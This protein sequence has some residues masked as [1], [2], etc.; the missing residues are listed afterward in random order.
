MDLTTVARVAQRVNPAGPLPVSHD[1]VAIYQNLIV[2][3]SEGVRRYLDRET[4]VATR[5][6]YLDVNEW[7]CLFYLKAWPITV[8]TGVWFDPDQGFTTDT[9][10]ASTDDF[11]NAAR[12]RM[13]EF[14]LK[15]PLVSGGRASRALKITYTG[16]MATS[17][18]AFIASYPDI[19]AAV[20]QQV[21][22]MWR[23]RNNAGLNS[24]NSDAGVLVHPFSPIHEFLLSVKSVLN[25][26][27]RRRA[28]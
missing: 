20:D 22:H 11:L 17:T 5:T 27:R 2:E 1:E 21:A 4:E 28:A 12:G 7:Q 24:I 25:R 26:H 15:A 10:L 23:T 16:G 18:E 3:V 13:G 8:V 9:A 6:E 19:A 14:E